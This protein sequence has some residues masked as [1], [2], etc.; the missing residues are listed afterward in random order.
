MRSIRRSPRTARQLSLWLAALA[1]ACL[2]LVPGRAHALPPFTLETVDGG[3]SQFVGEYSS[4]KL[5]RH[6]HPH[7]AYYDGL[8][9][10]LKYA[11]H[12]GV[13]W[14]VETADP[15]VADVG[16][17]ASLALDTLDRPHVA[18]YDQ[19]NGKLRYAVKLAAGW[20]LELADSSSFD[21]GW[22]PSIAIDSLGQPWIG[23]YDR[24]TGN[25]RLSRRSPAGVWSGQYA[26]TS[27][28][29][30]GFYASLAIDKKQRPH[31]AWY[32][33]TR[34]ML[35]YSTLKDGLWARETVD[36]SASNVGLY[37]SLKLDRFGRVQIAYM[38]LT[39]GT[40]WHAVREGSTQRWSRDLVDGGP[41]FVGYDCALTL[42]PIG[43]PNIS[44]H[45][46]TSLGLK[47]ARQRAAGWKLENVD[48]TPG[49]TGLY[50]SVACDSSGAIRIS[51]WDGTAYTLR[52]A[53]GPSEVLDAGPLAPPLARGLTL[54][55][56]P[57]R[58]GARVRLTSGAS[59]IATYE[60]Y[61]L[62][63]RRQARL[64]ADATGAAEWDT[65]GRD[66]RPSAPGVY[67]AR[68]LQRD[69]SL[70]EARRLALVR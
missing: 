24:G 3:P 42:D 5:D 64:P 8:A 18:Y 59:G 63:G 10:H 58:A 4:M 46:G 27:F 62:A 69:G 40:L 39:H 1:A 66:G 44:Y 47:F 25:P 32:N 49:I 9:G 20:K 2:V 31:M 26:D 30:S 28:D 41:D 70:G 48:D 13:A 52:F 38:D 45:D 7:V 36:S 43:Y 60:I 22:Y 68:A 51:Y 12:D 54:S 37:A 19:T 67:F 55:P 33:L 35:E 34:H 17:F 16:Q 23:S 21:C 14:I 6:G 15:S 29:L 57:A 61:D 56:N 65:R 11:R 50:S 53:W